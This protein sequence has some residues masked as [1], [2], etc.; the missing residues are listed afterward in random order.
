MDIDVKLNVYIVKLFVKKEGNIFFFLSDVILIFEEL[1]DN[2]SVRF[3]KYIVVYCILNMKRYIVL[4]IRLE[5]L[6]FLVFLL[7]LY[8]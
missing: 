3:L 2:N 6:K 7:R 4:Y 5:S 1:L 8:I